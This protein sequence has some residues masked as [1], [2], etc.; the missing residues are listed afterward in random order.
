LAGTSD[1]FTTTG[2]H[3]GRMRRLTVVQDAW[4]ASRGLAYNRIRTRLWMKIRREAA[5]P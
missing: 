3:T 5:R 4:A 2:I 1:R